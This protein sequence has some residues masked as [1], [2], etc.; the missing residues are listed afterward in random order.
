MFRLRISYGIRTA[1]WAC[2]LPLLAP[3]ARK[4]GNS[5]FLSSARVRPSRLMFVHRVPLA[6]KYNAHLDRFSGTHA[7]EQRLTRFGGVAPRLNRRAG[8]RIARRNRPKTS[9]DMS[10]IWATRKQNW[11]KAISRFSR[12][13]S[14][15]VETT[16]KSLENA[17]SLADTATF[18]GRSGSELFA[19]MPNL[20]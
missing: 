7:V 1:P 5:H 11:S 14:S 13:G 12:N 9:A 19:D 15:S 6:T 2:R 16:A 3:E 10:Q 4:G 20:G 17:P 8:A 18:R